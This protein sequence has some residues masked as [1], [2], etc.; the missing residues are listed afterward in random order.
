MSLSFIV[1]ERDCRLVQQA[2]TLISL[3]LPRGDTIE[4]R[5]IHPVVLI[6]VVYR[7]LCLSV[8]RVHLRVK[9]DLWENTGHGEGRRFSRVAK[10]EEQTHTLRRSF[11]GKLFDTRLPGWFGPRNSWEGSSVGE[12]MDTPPSLVLFSSRPLRFR[13]T[14]VRSQT[15]VVPE[16]L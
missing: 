5:V 13:W 3:S 15:P 2:T 9:F 11:R 4:C 1:G 12:V 8:L 7:H 14:T 16:Q 6:T 10:G